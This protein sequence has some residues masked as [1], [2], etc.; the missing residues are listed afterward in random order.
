MRARGDADKMRGAVGGSPHVPPAL[1]PVRALLEEGIGRAYPGAVLAVLHRGERVIRWAVGDRSLTPTRQPAEPETIYDLASLTKVVVTVPLILQAA[2]EGR[3]TL[4]DAVA[5]HLPECGP[6]AITLR[7]LLS[8][9]S[10]LPAW[11]PFYLEVAGYDAVVARAAAKASAAVP[12]GPVVYSDLGFIL[13]GEVVR[14][15]LG[16]TLDVLARGRLFAPLGMIDT[17]YSPDRALLERIAPTEDGTAIEQTMAGEAGRRHT[18]RRRLIWGE[19]HDSNAYAMDGVSGHAGVFGTAD[20]LIAYC[21]MWLDGGRGPNGRLLDAALVREATADQTR[22]AGRGLGWALTGP[23][24][25]WGASLSPRAF[26]HTGFTGTSLVID[27]DHDLALV[28]LTNAI[29]LGRDRTEILALR[30]RIA[31]AVAAALL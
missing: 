20:D 4:D 31:A 23:Q 26:G 21:R 28:L 7:H 17:S 15:T 8:H 16:A 1:A 5:A 3:L 10:G 6:S 14:R 29:H 27:P 12:G 19:V 13:L 22:G 11:I 2:A 25:W 30:P 18:W 24:G 9:T